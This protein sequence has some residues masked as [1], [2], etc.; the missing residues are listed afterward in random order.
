MMLRTVTI[1]VALA[2]GAVA[3]FGPSFETT[4]SSTYGPGYGFGVGSYGDWNKYGYVND[5]AT[6]SYRS[7]GPWFTGSGYS[8]PGNGPWLSGNGVLR[9]A[10]WNNGYGYTGWSRWNPWYGPAAT[11]VAAA[12]DV[13]YDTY[14]P[15]YANSVYGVSG[16]PSSRYAHLNYENAVLSYNR[17]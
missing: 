11:T 5:V 1:L 12:N 10:N 6:R 7:N 8:F 9:G 3:Y 14:A 15:T 16:W 13:V 4:V 17:Y 2:S